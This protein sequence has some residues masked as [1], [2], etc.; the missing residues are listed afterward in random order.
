MSIQFVQSLKGR[1]E[2][3]I[4]ILE[5]NIKG[6]KS[7]NFLIKTRC[8]INSL[9]SIAA[10]LVRIKALLE[11][12]DYNLV[13]IGKI[14]VG[15]TTAICHLF[16]LFREEKTVGKTGKTVNKISELL[17][18]GSGRTTICEVVIQPSMSKRS[19]LEI[20]PYSDD[21]VK[22]FIRELCIY[23][24]NKERDQNSE[25]TGPP[26]TELL[27]AIRN[28]TDLR[29][30]QIEGKRVDKAS[31]LAQSSKNLDGFLK[32]VLERANLSHRNQTRLESL[33][34]FESVE[35]ERKW[36][37]N[38]FSNLN[39]GKM[40]KFSLPKRIYVGV[41][42]KLIEFNK[43]PRF[44]S[45]IDT[46]G[47][48]DDARDR[49]DLS[50]YI[51]NQDNSICLFAEQFPAAPSNV[52][53]LLTRYLT[54][55]SR[56]I[57]TKVALLV[58]SRKGEPEDVVNLDGKVEDR[59]EGIEVRKNQIYDAF[60][61][62][63][64]KFLPKNI[65]FY[66]ALQFYDE[67]H[68]L[69]PQYEKDDVSD[70]RIKLLDAIN[71][72]ISRRERALLQEAKNYEH[73]FQEVIKSGG[74][75]SPQEEKLINDLKKTIESHEKTEFLSNFENRYKNHLKSYHATVF[76]AINNR[77]GTYDLRDID[78]YFDGSTVAEALLRD[79]FRE[80]KAEI[81]GAVELVEKYASEQSGLKPVMKI[82]SEQIDEYFEKFIIEIGQEICCCIK[83][84][85]AP[86]TYSNEFWDYAQNRWGQGHGYRDDVLDQY[87][88]Q[89]N[90]LD[91]W[92]VERVQEVWKQNFMDRILEF[93]GES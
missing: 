40:D 23:F 37:R 4:E 57:D 93:F 72:L 22:E 80:S 50:N 84:S 13:F 82:L 26:P 28:I 35:D 5:R 55:E 24:W 47:M 17:S 68:I 12:Q 77:F 56:D 3:E 11:I 76:R 29:D 63:N 31:E 43:Y 62:E 32:S 71:D 51:R 18:T 36:L 73:I 67:E 83:D 2:S 61:R 45:I 44:R 33:H 15:K 54:R 75:L 38:N 39:L 14:G 25:V 20:E 6:Q 10:R 46:R 88:S 59:N 90:S 16:N 91:D 60:A 69:K 9:K 87:G 21:E 49:K 86:Q 30:S 85:L 89:I 81:I 70:A 19:F 27:R 48:D 42:N 78:I 53:E 66:D 52:S 1:I 41:S 7:V 34:D 74:G 58:L 8:S 65:F 92:L 79:R 64:I